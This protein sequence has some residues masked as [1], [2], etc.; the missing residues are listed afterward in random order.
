MDDK[1]LHNKMNEMLECIKETNDSKDRDYMALEVERCRLRLIRNRIASISI[2]T[3]PNKLY[4]EHKRIVRE[5]HE[6]LEN[7]GY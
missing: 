5:I 3:P 7:W 6:L 4:D 2:F 1:A